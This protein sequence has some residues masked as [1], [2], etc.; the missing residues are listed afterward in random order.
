MRLLRHLR[1]I[2]GLGFLT[3]Q[4]NVVLL[5]LGFTRYRIV[6]TVR[7]HLPYDPPASP[8]D[9]ALKPECMQHCQEVSCKSIQRKASPGSSSVYKFLYL[10]DLS[11]LFPD[12]YFRLRIEAR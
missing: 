4:N 5:G 2:E 3:A 1:H 12:R 6:Q 9:Y 11:S 8:A 10:S 7:C